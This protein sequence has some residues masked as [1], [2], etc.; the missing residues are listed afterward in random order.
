MLSA[1]AGAGIGL[2]RPTSSTVWRLIYKKVEER[3]FVY[4]QLYIYRNTAHNILSSYCGK[5]T[6]LQC[7]IYYFLTAV[8]VQIYSA[9]YIIFILRYM[10]RITVHN[11]LY[12][13]FGIC[14]ELQC[15]IYYFLTAVCVQNCS[16]NYIIFLKY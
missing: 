6:E 14:T 10:C 13:F 1:L 2:G 16:A 7:K 3:L 15:I 5:C 4:L 8:Y 11:I 9:Q 12:S